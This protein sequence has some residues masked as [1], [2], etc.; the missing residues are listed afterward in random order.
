MN[1]PLWTQDLKILFRK[2]RLVEFWPTNKYTLNENVNAVSKFCIYAGIVIG[3]MRDDYSF[4]TG[5]ILICLLLALFVKPYIEHTNPHV[6]RSTRPELFQTTSTKCQRP[7]KNNPFAN[8]LVTDYIDNPDKLAACP[9]DEVQE[10]IDNTFFDG[11]RKDPYDLYGKK[12]GQREF[13][14]MPN[15]KIPNDQTNFAQWLYG[16][17]NQTCKENPSMCTG[18]DQSS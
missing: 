11:F 3:F 16:S 9:S 4:I 10:E 18:R 5:A 15:T 6:V 13:M 1:D 12:H 17:Q 8:V 2:E 7:S 14:S